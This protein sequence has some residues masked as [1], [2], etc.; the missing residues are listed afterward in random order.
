MNPRRFGSRAKFAIPAR[1]AR[2]RLPR[3]WNSANIPLENH[4]T[5]M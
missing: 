2:R 3:P 1:K 4:S 5:A